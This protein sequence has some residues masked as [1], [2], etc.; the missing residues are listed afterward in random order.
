MQIFSTASGWGFEN[1]I[2]MYCKLLWIFSV[3]SAMSGLFLLC[4]LL[5]GHYGHPWCLLYMCSLWV[6]TLKITL[7]N[8]EFFSV[9]LSQMFATVKLSYTYIVNMKMAILVQYPANLK[10]G[11]WTLSLYG[12][13]FFIYR[14]YCLNVAVIC[15]LCILFL[16]T[17][18]L[19]NVIRKFAL[20]FY[21]TLMYSLKFLEVFIFP[22]CKYGF[23]FHIKHWISFLYSVV[24]NILSF[25]FS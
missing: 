25:I 9:L 22:L 12:K 10:L 14:S 11:K 15:S 18:I 23:C 20:L 13:M 5:L 3:E 16:C 21:G 6:F 4:S 17:D 8:L 24:D 2:H 1:S 19:S 7:E